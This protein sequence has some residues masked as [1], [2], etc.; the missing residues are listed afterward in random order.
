MRVRMLVLVLFAAACS[1]AAAGEAG[2]K[3]A[4][5][6]EAG[7]AKWEYR[8]LS[9]DQVAELGKKDFAAGLNKLGD[10]GW[11]LVAVESHALPGGGAAY[12][13]L[14]TFYFKR[15][16][17]RPEARVESPPPSQEEIKAFRLK[18]AN[19]GAVKKALQELF[20]ADGKRMRLVA[21]ERTNQ[22]IVQASTE[23]LFKIAAILQILDVAAEK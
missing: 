2:D 5:S 7:A 6:K 21:D 22:V 3:T 20:G 11:E 19:A 10:E 17:A 13:V 12:S 1:P 4:K 18:H 16:T 9:R 8:A 23:D 15:P 14:A